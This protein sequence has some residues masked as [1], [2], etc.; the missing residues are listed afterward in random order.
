M[1]HDG[2][3]AALGLAEGQAFQ[4]TFA[5]FDVDPAQPHRVLQIVQSDAG[6]VV[7]RLD[8]AD[9]SD[10]P[11][12]LKIGDKLN[13]SAAAWGRLHQLGKLDVRQL[14]A[15][16]VQQSGPAPWVI[17]SPYEH[18]RSGDG[19]GFWSEEDGWTRLEAATR[20]SERPQGLLPICNG[21][22]QALYVGG[23]RDFRLLVRERSSEAEDEP[24]MFF[25]CF[26]DDLPH[27]IEQALDMYPGCWPVGVD[28]DGDVRPFA[29]EDLR[30][31]W[32]QLGE[33]PAAASGRLLQNFLHFPGGASLEEVWNWFRTANPEFRTPEAE[34]SAAPA[35]RPRG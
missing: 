14:S 34:E 2:W 30:E 26:A 4:G 27:A 29:L 13:I 28:V 6:Q 35:R 21:S 24:P 9:L 31:V 16:Q 23:M 20:Y 12:V 17:W 10:V 33:A 5:G 15:E 19:G 22:S 1:S 11:A 8:V 7:I 25:Q 3:R 32:A 18:R